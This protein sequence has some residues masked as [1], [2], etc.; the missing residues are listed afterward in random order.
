MPRETRK[1]A[2]PTGPLARFLRQ[3]HREGFRLTCPDY[4]RVPATTRAMAVSRR[5][6]RTTYTPYKG[7]SYRLTA[8]GLRVL[9]GTATWDDYSSRT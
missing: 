9:R 1:P 7:W 6:V 8:K 4:W 5:M 3:V 2:R